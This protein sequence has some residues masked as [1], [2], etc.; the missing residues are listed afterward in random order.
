MVDPAKV[1][2]LRECAVCNRISIRYLLGE[3]RVKEWKDF[4]EWVHERE[5]QTGKH[6]EQEQERGLMIRLF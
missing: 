5:R 2:P 6:E 1:F 3:G 4:L